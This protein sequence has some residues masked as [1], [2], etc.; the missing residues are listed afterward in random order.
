[1]AKI[2]VPRHMA[3]NKARRIIRMLEC[4]EQESVVRRLC[5]LDD[6]KFQ[7]LKNQVVTNKGYVHFGNKNESYM[8]EEEMLIGYVAP[9][10]DELSEVE[11]EMYNAN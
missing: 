4:G 1:M 3:E 9:S 10:Y 7:V 11:K 5:N 2:I 6:K 8:T